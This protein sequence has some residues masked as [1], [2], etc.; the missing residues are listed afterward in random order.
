MK[1]KKWKRFSCLIFCLL[2]VG[3]LIFSPVTASKDNPKLS[4]RK[5]GV[6]E[7]KPSNESNLTPAK[8]VELAF[9]DAVNP[10]AIAIMIIMLTA[11]LNYNPEDKKKVLLAGFAFVASIFV[12]YLFYGIVIINL[13]KWIQSFFTS[14]KPLIYVLVGAF[15]VLLG[16]MN[17]SDYI[18]YKPGSFL[19]EM[20]MFLRPKMKKITKG[21]TSPKGAAV[22]GIFVTLFLLPCTVGPY[23]A[24]LGMLSFFELIDTLPWLLFYNLIFVSP[25]IGITLLIYWGAAEVEDVSQWRERNI[26]YMH[27]GAGIVILG[28]GACMALAGSITI[29]RDFGVNFPLA[30]DP[31]RWNFMIW[32]LVLGIFVPYLT[33][34]LDNK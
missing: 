2:G 7:K 29:L 26:K 15:A 33:H 18:N 13:F 34:H 3:L 31:L 16:I 17:L 4:N 27:L 8:A 1:R 21:I 30:I 20:P 25:M 23:V 9:A 6:Q 24:A 14:V 22:T 28:I 12:T 5:P 32:P 10:C 11:I 19:T